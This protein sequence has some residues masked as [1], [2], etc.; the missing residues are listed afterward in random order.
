MGR[1]LHSHLRDQVKDF[2]PIHV[3]ALAEQERELGSV[4][5]QAVIAKVLGSLKVKTK[6]I[7]DDK[8]LPPQYTQTQAAPDIVP[9]V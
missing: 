4:A 9:L 2:P 6:I 3:Q 7:N 1:S 8:L 5:A